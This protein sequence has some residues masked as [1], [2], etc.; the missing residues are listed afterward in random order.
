MR[1]PRSRGKASGARRSRVP[2][3]L[4]A[5]INLSR[6]AFDPYDNADYDGMPLLVMSPLEGAFEV[7]RI[8]VDLVA[9]A[10]SAGVTDP[11][12]DVPVARGPPRV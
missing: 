9:F 7:L 12:V 3:A 10:S 2:A 8:L 5:G 11:N 4:T 6:V 1:R